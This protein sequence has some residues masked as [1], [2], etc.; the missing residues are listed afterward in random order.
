VDSGFVIESTFMPKAQQTTNHPVWAVN[1]STTAEAIKGYNFSL[2]YGG[3]SWDGD[4]YT[5]VVT[6][7]NNTLTN[8]SIEVITSQP[9]GQPLT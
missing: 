6:L 3:W 4:L 2:D 1:K 7:G 5:D 9:T 8:M